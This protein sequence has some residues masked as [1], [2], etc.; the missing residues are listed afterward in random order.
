MQ[1]AVLTRIVRTLH[2][3]GVLFLADDDFTWNFAAKG[4]LW[5]FNRNNTGIDVDFNTRGNSDW[6]FTDT[7]HSWS[8]L[9]HHT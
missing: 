5:A 3:H 2:E 6:G 4:T 7:R 9:D 8:L 1:C